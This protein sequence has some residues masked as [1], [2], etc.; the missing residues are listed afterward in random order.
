MIIEQ[1]T[2]LLIAAVA[3]IGGASGGSFGLYKLL[4]KSIVRRMK[5]LE[6]KLDIVDKWTRMQ[7]LDID[8]SN[9]S[10][11]IMVEGMLACLEGLREQ[12]CNGT[13]VNNIAKIK[14]YLIEKAHESKSGQR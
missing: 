5:V 9:K 13:V 3:L 1:F 8:N 12:G 6:E 4:D 14:T 11:Q 7:Q 2:E 10:T